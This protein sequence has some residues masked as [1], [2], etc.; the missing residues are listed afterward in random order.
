M[1]DDEAVAFFIMVSAV[2][3]DRFCRII[4]NAVFS[5]ALSV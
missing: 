1:S 5:F 3:I 2:C 4:L